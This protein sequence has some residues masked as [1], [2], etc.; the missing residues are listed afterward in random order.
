M[1]LL[2]GGK[3]W[4]QS[5]WLV[6]IEGVLPIARIEEVTFGNAAGRLSHAPSSSLL[7][8]KQ[9]RERLG[10]GLAWIERPGSCA[11]PKLAPNHRLFT[12]LDTG[13]MTVSVFTAE[14]PPSAALIC[15]EEG[16]MLRVVLCHYE[17]STATM[18]KE[19]VIRMETPILDKAN[20]LGWIKMT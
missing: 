17:R 1:Q 10:E 3:V 12:L 19:T 14:R 16:G 11:A 20:L 6:G 18:H 5:P 15:G 8:C 4:A 9:A 13:S 2:Y 7:A